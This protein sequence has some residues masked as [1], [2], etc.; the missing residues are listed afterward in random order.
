MR[1]PIRLTPIPRAPGVSRRSATLGYLGRFTDELLY[2]SADVLMPTIRRELGLS[3][4][5]VALLPL[6]LDYVAAVVEPAAGLLIDLWQRRW[7]LAWGAA[8][9]GLSLVVM[10]VAPTFLIMAV[11]FGIYGLGSG[12]LAH[13]ADAVIVDAH[14]EAPSR[15]FARGTTLDTIG[16]LLA[17]LIVSGGLWLGVPWRWL[18][19][20]TGLLGALIAVAYATTS[21][22]RSRG[23]SAPNEDDDEPRIR[24]VWTNLRAA[25]GSREARHWLGVLLLYD[26]FQAID[27]LQT[28]WLVDVVGLTQAQVGL[29]IAFELVV[30][31]AG[32]A[33]LDRWL[34]RSAGRQVLLVSVGVLAVVFP[35]WLLVPGVWPR[36]LLSAP[37]N[38]ADSAIWPVAK[39]GS[40]TSVPGRPGT[41]GALHSV[42]NLL[43][44][45]AV[46][47]LLA[48]VFTL[49]WAMLLVGAPALAGLWLVC[50][51]LPS[52][53]GAEVQ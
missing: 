31:L 2:G 34:T 33:Y 32:L 50:W 15:A 8:M 10:G 30:S 27:V 53:T 43:P 23:G 37:L 28:V 29:Y 6:A 19:I 1:S 16:A 48:E 35:A 14:P 21:F 39:S 26:A 9:C 11:G 20:G 24:E 12:P 52:R 17:P 13:T 47:G 4:A 25:L 36:V 22:P 49:T 46:V 40:L 18:L 51:R 38:F 5:Q 3:Y 7:L 41:V 45:G 42:T 44:L